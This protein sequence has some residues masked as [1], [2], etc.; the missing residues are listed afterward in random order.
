[1]RVS[2]RQFTRFHIQSRSCTKWATPRSAHTLETGNA[3]MTGWARMGKKD[4]YSESEVAGYL[5]I[6]VATL[7]LLLDEHVFNDGTRVTREL[8]FCDCEI[9]LLG[10]WNTVRKN[11]E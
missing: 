6:S 2:L 10:V 8:T 3:T 5:N 7:H 1:M 9:A 4:S 11:P